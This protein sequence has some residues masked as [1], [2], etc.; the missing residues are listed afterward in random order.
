[1]MVE[2]EGRE[3]EEGVV[4]KSGR[5]KWLHTRNRY[6]GKERQGLENNA[7]MMEMEEDRWW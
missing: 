1:M 5:D 7:K 3:D 2:M 6:A 4:M